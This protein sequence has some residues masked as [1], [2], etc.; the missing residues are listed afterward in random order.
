EGPQGRPGMAVVQDGGTAYLI[1]DYNGATEIL[2]FDLET[3]SWRVGPQFPYPVHHP[4]A[5]ALDGAVYV[6]GGYVDGWE[7]S[8]AV[9]MLDTER[10]EWNEAAPMPGPRAAG[11]AAVIEGRIHVVS[12][13]VSGAVKP[14]GHQR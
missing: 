9:W 14:V 5:A 8:D 4:M 6:F 11:G 1:G 2:L 12:G 10:L 7:A 13:S 3:G